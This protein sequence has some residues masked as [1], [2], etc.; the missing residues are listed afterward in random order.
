MA[1][2]HQTRILSEWYDGAIHNSLGTPDL[3]MN[4]TRLHRRHFLKHSALCGA[5]A[6]FPHVIPGRALG[7]NGTV[8][9]N[10]RINVALIGTGR[11]VFYAN[12]PWFL[13]SE[14]VQVVAVCD[15]DA[16]RME[17]AKKRQAH[18]IS[19]K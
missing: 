18:R 14:E 19:Q 12:L 4:T 16:W 3:L 7:A 10:N 8:A 1:A 17:Q 13:S 15:V 2:C 6:A 5:A 11:Q 9:P